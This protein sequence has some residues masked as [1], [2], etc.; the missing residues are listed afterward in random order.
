MVAGVATTIVMVIVN[1]GGEFIVVIVDDEMMNSLILLF[2][3]RSIKCFAWGCQLVSFFS[4]ML[5]YYFSSVV[6]IFD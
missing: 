5:Y 1:V 2:F 3:S 6:E 4:C